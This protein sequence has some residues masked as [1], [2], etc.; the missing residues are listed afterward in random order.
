MALRSVDTDR[1]RSI[2]LLYPALLWFL[3]FLFCLRIVGQAA[4]AA[5]H[6]E[7]LPPMSAW[8]SGLLPYPWLLAAQ[9]VVV[10]LYGKIC[11]DF[12]RSR[13]FFATPRRRLGGGLLAFSSFYLATMVARYAVRMAQ[14]PGERWSGGSIPTLFHW[15]L[16]AF[17][18]VVGAYHWQWTKPLPDIGPTRRVPDWLRRTPW[19][20]G[21][22]AA[23]GCALWLGYLLAPLP[24]PAF[25]R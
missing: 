21:L 18:M 24:P 1:P 9:V 19:I 10:V 2:P 7:F 23:G 5:L 14:F 20:V 3:L 4:V 8:Y 22:I 16:A 15:V 13:G 25:G 6:V 11:L 17:L 12:T